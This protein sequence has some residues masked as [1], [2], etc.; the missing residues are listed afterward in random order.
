MPFSEKIAKIYLGR[1]SSSLRNSASTRTNRKK[2]SVKS[3]NT[4]SGE[5]YEDPTEDPSLITEN[6]QLESSSSVIST[7]DKTERHKMS[8]MSLNSE[9][10]SSE[11]IVSSKN[12]SHA[13]V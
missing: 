8:E 3:G 11:T 4:I 13:Q 2:A 7:R 9:V 6:L 1:K 10:G 12:K 5:N